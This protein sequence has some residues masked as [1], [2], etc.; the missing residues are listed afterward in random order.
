M[1]QSPGVL[2]EKTASFTAKITG[3]LTGKGKPNSGK[4]VPTSTRRASVNP[5]QRAA[6]D[7]EYR[8]VQ[9]LKQQ[10]AAEGAGGGKGGKEAAREI[11]FA[12]Q[13]GDNPNT[14][15]E[16]NRV[17]T[18][19]Y[20]FVTFL[21]IFLFE[22]FSRVAYLYFLFQA[23]LSW[24]SVVSPYSGVGST[25]A[26]LF[27]LAVAAIKAIWEDV[28]R[29]QEDQRMNTSVTHRLNADG[30]V[31]DIP[32]TDVRVGDAIVVRDD[33]NFP[34][35]L[36]CLRSALP[37][38]VCFIRTTNLDGET[39]LKIRKPLDIKGLR[40]ASMAEVMHLDLTLQAESP[41]KNLH[42][43]RGKAVVRHE[44]YA[45]M[46]LSPG[47]NRMMWEAEGGGTPSVEV[48]VT[49]NEMLLRG[50]T[51]KNSSEIVGLVVY[52]GKQTRIQMNSTKTPLKIGECRG[53]TGLQPYVLPNDRE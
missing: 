21:P 25:A 6:A 7:A 20:N 43:F 8:T 14:L 10:D 24:W 16:T 44:E 18:S 48:A 27:V 17:V 51:L 3:G 5:Q 49:M 53:V 28:K 22:M 41:N 2:A 39:N 11:H 32:W 23:G 26:L 33:E 1:L 42:K 34:A 30:S 36:L 15:L 38:N 45:A 12:P 29:H 19:K 31:T 50:C 52:T 46:P 37:D 35:D 9:T 40:V 47:S 4:R 13:A